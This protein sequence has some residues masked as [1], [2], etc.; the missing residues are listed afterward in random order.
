MGK[1]W[2]EELL[3]IADFI[4]PNPDEMETFDVEAQVKTIRELGFNSQHIEVNDITVGEA[5]ITFFRSEHAIEQRE[6]DLLELYRKNYV[7]YGGNDLIYFNV[8][9][10]NKDL[11][12]LHTEWFQL[13]SN[14]EIIPIGY[15]SGGYSCIN[16]PFRDWAFEILKDLG[17]YGIKGVFLDG[18]V[19][20]GE[21]CYC[22]ACLSKF[23]KLHGFRYSPENIKDI[24]VFKKVLQ[25]KHDS[26]S[27]FVKDARDALKSVNEDAIIYMNGLPLGPSTCGRSNRGAEKYQDA[28]LAEGGFL[29]GDLRTL[30]IW[31]PAASAKFLEA[32][33]EGKP[34]I[35]A[36]AGRHSAWNRYL[37]TSAETWI[38]Y[39]MSI[40]NGANIWYGIYDT[41][42]SDERMKTVK[43]IN[44]LLSTNSKYL[45]CTSSVSKIAL[46]WSMKNANL[47]QTTTEHWDFVKERST[48][49]DN[50]KSDS[51]KAFNAWFDVLQRSHSMFDIIDDY[52]I[53]NKD[54]SKYELVIL[55][56]IAC[57]SKGETGKI[58]EYVKN[59]GNII[60]TYD[61]SCYDEAGIL[62]EDMQLSEV[63]GVLK[64]EGTTSL[65]Y[66]HIE[67]EQSSFT[68]GI[69][70]SLIP[71]PQLYLKVLPKAGTA[72]YMSFRDKQTSRYCDLP[73]KTQYPL[74]M[75]NEYG[76]GK[77]VMFTGSIDAT[78][79]NYRFPEYFDIMRN[80]VEFL[81]N[82]LIFIDKRITSLFVNIR[83][84]GDVDVLHLVNFASHSGRPIREVIPCKDL[85]VKIKV[86]K[87][88]STLKT[89]RGGKTLPF[90]YKEGF[91][92]TIVPEIKEY[93]II[94]FE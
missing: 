56:N 76:K 39:A 73:S 58:Q 48:T 16:S 51:R 85:E 46:V 90:E 32:Q 10:L 68:A 9:W 77:A 74:I 1:K 47:Y 89:L 33:A 62:A 27:E 23:E 80:T 83:R 63:L 70:Q 7:K 54:M 22:E 4:P 78:Y 92:S 69:D 37:L 13:F 5:G 82:K 29:S 45:S 25:Y 81:S 2:Y 12:H 52:H 38:N 35:V 31:K 67:I 26:I 93:E 88:P 20:N 41:N 50:L 55:P 40:A 72:T 28:L 66:D 60:T 19:F 6:T 21:G 79:E 87:K 94:I 59:G 8:H 65:D 34:V 61:T 53:E 24:N 11:M 57:M 17:V 36:I 14:K 43:E 64:A 30:P 3:L 42:R 15:G 71:A 86:K 75:V 18:P 84:K 44:T 91:V 49:S